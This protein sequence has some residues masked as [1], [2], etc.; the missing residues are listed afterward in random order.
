MSKTSSVVSSVLLKWV[1]LA[2][3]AL[4][5]SACGSSSSNGAGGMAG[6]GSVIDGAGTTS[7]PGT[8]AGATGQSG[9]TGASG[10]AT[11]ASGATATTGGATATTGGATGASGATSGNPEFVADCTSLFTAEC[12]QIY[13]CVSEADRAGDPNVGST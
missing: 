4:P 13:A 1:C 6:E 5:L 12:H 2:A 3:L 8:S 7:G 11:G 9:A 10:G